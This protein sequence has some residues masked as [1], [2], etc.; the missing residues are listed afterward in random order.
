MDGVRAIE[1]KYRRLRFRKRLKRLPGK[2][3]HG[4]VFICLALVIRFAAQPELPAAAAG[5]LCVYVLDIGQGDAVLLQTDTH[6]VLIDGGETDQGMLLVQTLHALGIMRLD[7]IINSHPHSDH[8]G[9]L[10]TVLEQMPVDTLYLADIPDAMLPE[11]VSLRETVHAADAQHTDIR[12]PVCHETL[13]LGCAEIEFLTVDNRAF[14]NLNDCSIGCRVTCGMHSFFFAGDLEEAG[15]SAFLEAG[16]VSPVTVLKA[17]HHGSNTSS[18]EA[19]LDAAKPAYAVISAG[20]LNDYGH[21]AEKC[22]ARLGAASCDIFRTDLDGA[23]LFKTDGQVIQ[24]IENNQF[25]EKNVRKMRPLHSRRVHFLCIRRCES[26]AFFVDICIVS[27]Y[28]K[29]EN[30][31]GNGGMSYGFSYQKT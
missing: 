14:D 29:G 21:P 18:S 20:V 10:R 28:N 4:A 25:F 17:S 6:A 5:T 2:L 26:S 23:I 11:T 24:I 3:L 31:L 22:L 12:Y 13:P 16:L 7:C 9:G 30:S 15:E 8:L 19:F 1:R 27:C